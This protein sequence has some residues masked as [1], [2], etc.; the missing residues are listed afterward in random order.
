MCLEKGQGSDLE[1]YEVSL[2]QDKGMHASG[3]PWRERDEFTPSRCRENHT[4]GPIGLFSLDTTARK[5]TT[6]EYT[7]SPVP[8]L[9]QLW[10]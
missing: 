4:Q 9:P 8:P 10:C 2:G 3:S 6:G 1:T 5:G 7:L